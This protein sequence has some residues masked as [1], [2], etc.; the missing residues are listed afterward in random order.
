MKRATAILTLVVWAF[1]LWSAAGALYPRSA[2][3]A[4]EPLTP[5]AERAWQAAV[6]FW[7]VAPA[8]CATLSKGMAST[9]EL[10]GPDIPEGSTAIGRATIPPT[11]ASV[12]CTFRLSTAIVDYPTLCATAIHEYGHL[13]GLQHVPNTIME[14]TINLAYA[15]PTCFPEIENAAPATRRLYR[16][17]VRRGRI[18]APHRHKR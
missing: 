5:D 13:L 4:P 12:P 2:G 1:T 18:H 8:G 16:R 7:G 11:G 17:L 15:P 10:A 3:A 14:S 9:E 6:A